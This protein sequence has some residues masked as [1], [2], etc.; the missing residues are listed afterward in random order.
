MS[1]LFVAWVPSLESFVPNILDYSD[2]PAVTPVE[3]LVGRVGR[4]QTRVTWRGIFEF[5]QYDDICIDV[6]VS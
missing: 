6:N 2:S 1:V 3:F 5:L 4:T